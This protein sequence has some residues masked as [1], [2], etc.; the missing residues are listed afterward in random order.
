[1]P[2][3][4][5]NPLEEVLSLLHLA[6]EGLPELAVLKSADLASKLLGYLLRSL[7]D[8]RVEQYAADPDRLEEVVERLL[9]LLPG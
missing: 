1:M 3:R 6:I 2:A 4:L 7:R 9:Q 8:E 5:L